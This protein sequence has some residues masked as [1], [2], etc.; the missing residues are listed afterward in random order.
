[1]QRTF[2]IIISGQVQGV[3]FRPFVYGLAKQLQLKGSVSNNQDGVLIR[4]N[5]SE[6]KAHE[7]LLAILSGAPEISFIQNHNVSEIAFSPYEDFQIV[8]SEKNHQINIPLTPDFAICES[9]K[10]EIRDVGNRRFGYAFTTCTNC[11]PRYS[12]TTM[13][14]FER[15]NTTVSEFDMCLKCQTEYTNPEDRRFHSQTNSCSDCGIKLQLVD[16]DGREFNETQNNIIKKAAALIANG[17]ILAIKNTNGYLLCCDA[18]NKQAIQRLREKK[19]RPS[20]PFALLYP[21]IEKIKQDFEVSIPEEKALSSAIA[22]IVILNPKESISD[23]ELESI[24]P[25]LHQLGIML[26]SSSLL[27]LLMDELKIPII[28]TSGNIH[29]SPII[30]KKEEAVE[31]LIGVADYFLHH[32]LEIS[33]PQ[34]DSVVR[35]GGEHQIT[36][37]RSRGLAPNYM[38]NTSMKNQKVLAMG[39]HLKSTF[40]FTPNSH[41][42]VSPYF[43]NLDSYDV[44]E[45]FQESITKY[46]A[47]FETEPEVVLVDSHPQYQ[48]NIIGSQLA[49]N[50]NAKLVSIQH[51]KA[52]FASVLGEHNLFESEEKILGVVWDGT[53][54]GEDNS[55]WGGEFFSYHKNEMERLTHFEYVDW[56]AADKMAKEPR[57]SLLSVLPETDR[58]IAKGKFSE[59]EWKIY[60]KM[61]EKNSLK[62]SSVGRLFDAVASLLLNIDSTSYEGEAAMLL[63]NEASNYQD[64]SYINFLSGNAYQVIPTKTIIKG[65]HKAIEQGL[66]TA[67]IANSFI[68]TL[69]LVIIN[70]ANQNNYNYVVCSGG[71]FQNAILVKKLLEMAEKDH[72]E[73]KFNRILSS[74]DE[75]IS[76]GQLWYHQ[77]IKN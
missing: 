57:L 44:S 55:I 16:T 4:I 1:M 32:D 6:E 40:T 23:L 17:S 46:T 52:H 48:S 41:T 75:N 62:T 11:G 19:R 28:A 8:P 37:R 54:F 66:P 64:E 27:I 9:C 24:A 76:L 3:G 39:A 15:P 12:V 25:R 56:I 7:F 59:S 29:S 34:D 49:T 70:M 31:K 33:F 69:S 2:E 42:Y 35:F 22:P 26:P 58:H 36:L 51:H 68:H 5:T 60:N 21:S 61:L 73:L 45:R 53:G 63:E 74:N 77:H 20:K 30:S 43:G 50:W 65:I 38:G 18:N 10:S 71:V 14:P 72:V 13:F 47:L 67:Q